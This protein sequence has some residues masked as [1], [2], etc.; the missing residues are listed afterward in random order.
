M[1]GGVGVSDGEI[2]GGGGWCDQNR[3]EGEWR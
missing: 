3:R 1:D 2:Y